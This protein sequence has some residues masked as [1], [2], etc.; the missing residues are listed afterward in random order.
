MQ[1]TRCHPAV[2]EQ[3]QQQGI[4]VRSHP[5]HVFGDAPWYSVGVDGREH[6]DLGLMF[7]PDR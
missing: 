3:S 1:R 5:Y 4:S 6:L 2:I 7:V